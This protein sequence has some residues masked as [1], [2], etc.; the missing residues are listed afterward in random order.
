VSDAILRLLY[1]IL[2]AAVIGMAIKQGGWFPIILA[3]FAFTLWYWIM[4]QAPKLD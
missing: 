1:T 3:A 4:F 2:T